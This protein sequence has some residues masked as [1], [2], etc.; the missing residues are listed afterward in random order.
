MKTYIKYLFILLVFIYISKVNGQT[1][2]KKFISFNGISIELPDYFSKG[3]LVAGGTLQWFDNKIDKDIQLS[4]ESFGSGTIK[5]LEET[6][7]NDLKNEKNITYKV[8][9]KTWYVI[10]GINEDGIFYNKSIIKNGIQY[11]LRIIYQIKNKKLLES[12]IGRISSSF[13]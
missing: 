7:Q 4:I 1:T 11:H 2:W 6:F 5:D 8:K 12:L 10:S 9:K 13:K 3:I